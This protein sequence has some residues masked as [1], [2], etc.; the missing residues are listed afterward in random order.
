[1][2][3]SVT[4]GVNAMNDTADLKVLTA[5]R[6]KMSLSAIAFMTIGLIVVILVTLVL[7]GVIYVGV[8]QPGQR[9]VTQTAVCST[10]DVVKKLNG[11]LTDVAND[12]DRTKAKQAID[13]VTSLSSYKSDPTCA[14]AL[15]RFYFM[16]R[17]SDNFGRQ[18]DELENFAK[19][20]Q[21]PSNQFDSLTSLNS[22]AI[23]YESLTGRSR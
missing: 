11:Y 20:G 12:G 17:D 9:L 21:Y 5:K 1:M 18:V 3:I 2:G 22:K 14:E 7:L 15:A 6:R 23:D 19:Q 13:Y 4:T 8:K 16:N 10:D